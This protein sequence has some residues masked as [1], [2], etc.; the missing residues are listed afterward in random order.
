M[1]AALKLALQLGLRDSLVF[2]DPI[3]EDL[4]D[5]SRFVALQQ[6][7]DAIFTAEHDRVVPLICF[8]NPIPCAWEPPRE[9]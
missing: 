8:N 9:T 4:R 2:K 5:E 3:F 1:I 7:L 6:Q